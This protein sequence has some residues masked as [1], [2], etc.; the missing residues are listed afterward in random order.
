MKDFRN[1][2]KHQKRFKDTGNPRYRL[3]E[4][5]AEIIRDYRRAIDE[6]ENEGLDP[7]TL[8]SGWIKNKKASLYFR[9]PK[10]L[11][12]DFKKLSKELLEEVKQYSP[13]YPTIEREKY[14]DGHLLFM[15]PSDLHIGKL[16]KS[17]LS[18]EEYN[19]QIAVT[20]ALEGVKGCLTKSQGFNVEKTILLLS[21]DLLH[22]DNFDNTT[23]RGTKQ[24]ETDG[25]LSDHFQI[26]KRLMV[27]IIE[28]LLQVSTVHVMFTPGNHDNTVGWMV[29]ELLAVWFRHNKDVTFDVSL[30]MRKYYKYKNNLISSCHGHKIKLDLLPMIVA[31]ECEYWSESKYR[32]MFTQHIHHKIQKQYPGLWVESLMSTSGADIYHATSGY[33]SSNNK[34]IEAFLFSEYGQVA[35]ITHLF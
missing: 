21:G 35:R 33:Q 18:G 23:T 8:H 2:K 27:E 17:F 13:K 1:N 14:K 22:V 20:R 11:E 3:T 34:A 7:E 28:T 25:L 5:E 19:N 32:Y 10:P 30:Q 16:C 12:K 15:C 29:A 4:T 24:N 31:D 26:A 6:C 9:M